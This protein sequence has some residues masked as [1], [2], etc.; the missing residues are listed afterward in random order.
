MQI[1]GKSLLQYHCERLRKCG[2]PMV[3]ATTTNAGDDVLAKFGKENSL[4]VYRGSEADVLGRFFGAATENR[5]DVIIRVTSD[6]PLID[7]DLI[8]KSVEHYRSANDP[9][10]YM[11]NGV[12]RTFPRGFDF[13]IFSY[14]MLKEAFE[15]AKE[16][17]EREHV[18]PYFYQNKHGRTHFH[19][20]KRDP[21]MSAIR[22]T[23]D[24]LD[25]FKLIER[26]IGEFGCAELN[27]AEICEVFDKHPELKL[28]NQHI[29]QKKL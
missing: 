26:L 10:L 23:V 19:H 9:W 13:E 16:P 12:E 27:E 5:L 18:S 7:G 1:S 20:V 6:C 8:K 4:H 17:A 15:N 2:L 25:D 3:L 11:S 22:L 29:E 28:I 24:E 14:T 21:D